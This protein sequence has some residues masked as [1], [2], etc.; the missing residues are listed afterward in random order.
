MCI[1]A[2]LPRIYST[3]NI[4]FFVCPKTRKPQLSIMFSEIEVGF[5]LVLKSSKEENSLKEKTLW[6]ITTPKSRT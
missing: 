3:R 6:S 2:H 1:S 4:V 5:V